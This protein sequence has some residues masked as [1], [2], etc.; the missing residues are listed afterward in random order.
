MIF[1]SY[2]KRGGAFARHHSHP[3]SNGCAEDA[4][5]LQVVFDSN[6]GLV[7]QLSEVHALSHEDM[8][9]IGLYRA[10]LDR[11]LRH[12]KNPDLQQQFY[13]QLIVQIAV[14][15]LIDKVFTMHPD[16]PVRYEW[17]QSPD[18]EKALERAGKKLLHG[19]P[20]HCETLREFIACPDR[21]VCREPYDMP[22]HSKYIISTTRLPV[23]KEEAEAGLH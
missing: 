8:G 20:S 15:E 16:H 18:P 10:R 22:L 14:Q 5:I 7:C 13:K 1:S 2:I 9:P 23:T 6:L 4:E 19:F 21:W 17:Q 3:E 11:R 12:L